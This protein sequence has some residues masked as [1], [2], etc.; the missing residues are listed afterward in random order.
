MPRAYADSL[1]ELTM[2]GFLS[3][4]ENL[5]STHDKSRIRPSLIAS[6]NLT[7]LC[8]PNYDFPAYHRLAF[9]VI[10]SAVESIVYSLQ[11]ETRPPEHVTIAQRIQH[12]RSKMIAT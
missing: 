12:C 3:K 11:R 10:S 5:Q 2:F 9:H 8:S 7:I 1:I 4:R 6:L